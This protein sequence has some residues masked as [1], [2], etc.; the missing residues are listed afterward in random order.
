MKER[1]FRKGDP[2]RDMEHL[3]QCLRERRWIYW[4]HKPLHPGWIES[5]TFRTLR[6]AV[7]AGI[8]RVARLNDTEDNPPMRTE[9]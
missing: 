5:M 8:L 9:D 7:R 2:I 4:N 3:S 1:K 6:G